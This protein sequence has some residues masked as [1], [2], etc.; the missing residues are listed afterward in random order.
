METL[1]DILKEETK[2]LKKQFL[3]K[4][5]EWTTSYYNLISK[6]FK[7][8]E[9][10]WC[11]F[12]GIEPEVSQYRSSSTTY[13]KSLTYPSGFYNT[14]KSRE[15]KRYQNEVRRLHKLG[16]NGYVTSEMIRAEKHYENSI[17]KLADRI[18][19]KGLDIS[20]IKATTSHIG[21]NIDTTLTDGNKTVHAYTIIAEGPIQRPHY[22]YLI[23]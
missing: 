2:T 17:T 3:E 4:T 6:R 7:W 20:K 21:V 11:E 5:K 19:K 14:S 15:L 1:I 10:E 9:I 18:E 23:K 13:E 12:L 8:F 22:R 16:L